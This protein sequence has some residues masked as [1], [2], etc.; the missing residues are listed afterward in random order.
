MKILLLGG[1][2]EALAIARTLPSNALYSLAG[3]GRIPQDLPCQVR[4][5]GYGGA[6]GLAAF[7]HSE[8]IDLLL[9]AT[10][11][12][13]ARI[14][15]NA[16]QAATRAGI[17]CWALRRPGWQAGPND[18][19]REVADWTELQA[20][21]APFVR[22]FFTLGRE[23]LEHLGE[24]PAQQFWTLRLLDDHPGAERARII[25]DRGP[26]ALEAERALFAEGD[27][28]VLISKNSGSA[29]TQ[30]K[31]QVAR[32]RGLPVLI[33]HRPVLPS[34]DR[35]F[36]SVADLLAALAKEIP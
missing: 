14:S 31:L 33:L 36:A 6:E 30:P 20:A 8:G 32:E 27:F 35:E 18:D 13:A 23:P 26:F 19:W 17:P 34:V 9:D 28:D 1:T 4:V 16:A 22:P 25:A 5:G 10:H 3:L 24:I 7:L 21:L 29:A 2:T 15:H 11:P 12:Y